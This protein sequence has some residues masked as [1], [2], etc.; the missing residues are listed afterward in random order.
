MVSPSPSA[1]ATSDIP[2]NANA[3]NVNVVTTSTSTSMPLSWT[4]TPPAVLA[5]ALLSKKRPPK[6]PQRTADAATTNAPSVRRRPEKLF[7]S[8][9][10]T[11]GHRGEYL[12]PLPPRLAGRNGGVVPGLPVTPQGWMCLLALIMAL[13]DDRQMLHITPMIGLLL[14]LASELA[15]LLSSSAFPSFPFDLLSSSRT[16]NATT[17]TTHNQLMTRL[18]RSPCSGPVLFLFL[19]LALFLWSLFSVLCPPLSVP[20]SVAA[21]QSPSH[22]PALDSGT[23]SGMRGA[24]AG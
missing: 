24:G 22:P 13:A 17:L 5:H 11:S 18:S 8:R 19:F 12:F 7:R 3:N 4:S 10:R 14:L 15:V 1:S 20:V 9:R 23:P 21:A 2:T 16:M 6:I